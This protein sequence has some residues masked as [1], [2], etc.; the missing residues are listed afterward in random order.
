[1]VV[2]SE[3]L[4]YDTRRILCGVTPC[5]RRASSARAS[6]G[7]A[8]TY[9][10]HHR[11]RGRFA[12]RT[13]GCCVIFSTCGSRRGR[14][15][16]SQNGGGCHSTS[17]T[18]LR[19]S[20]KGSSCRPATKASKGVGSRSWR[21]SRAGAWRGA[22]SCQFGGKGVGIG[23]CHWAASICSRGTHGRVVGGVHPRGRRSRVGGKDAL[24]CS[25]AAYSSGWGTPYNSWGVA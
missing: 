16:G 6:P 2:L 25:S 22:N 12:W 17:P 19:R 24:L 3:N 20:R 21:S 10:H 18:S 1:M 13:F 4:R 15:G 23:G 8:G 14:Q 5:V 9:K 11:G 7:T